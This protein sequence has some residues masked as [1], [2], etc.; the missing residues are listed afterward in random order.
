[1]ESPM[2]SLKKI[3]ESCWHVGFSGW[4]KTIGEREVASKTCP[5]QKSCS[6]MMCRSP[7]LTATG[8]TVQGFVSPTLYISKF[9]SFKMQ[10]TLYYFFLFYKHLMASPVLSAFHT[11]AYL[12]L[13]TTQWDEYY[14]YAHFQ[15]R[16]HSEV[17]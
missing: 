15:K 17:N 3:N 12:T 10:N 5:S 16:R 11:L 13:I 6:R 8:A 4:S 14:Y 2:R 9:Q 7:A 1:M